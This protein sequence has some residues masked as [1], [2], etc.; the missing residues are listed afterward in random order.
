MSREKHTGRNMTIAAFVAGIVGY[1][2]GIL[3]A[4]K[5]GKETRDDIQKKA[6]KAKSDAEK[7][8]KAA[9]SELNSLITSGKG[10]LQSAQSTAKTELAGAIE[11]AQVAK[12]KAR[13]LLSAVHEGGADDKDLQKAI[14]EVNS[15][16]SHLKKYVAKDARSAKK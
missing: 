7:K 12:D 15:A 16:I 1:V 3:T 5:S 8:L 14:K 11:T 10:K 2:T 9:H 13:E 4:P 6:A